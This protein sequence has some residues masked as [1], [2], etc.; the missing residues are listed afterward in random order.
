MKYIG[1]FI[2]WI[3]PKLIEYLLTHDGTRRPGGG[4]NPDSEEFRR[5]TSVGYD[6]TKTYWH[7]YDDKSTTL[8]ITPPIPVEGNVLWWFIKMTPG[9]FMPMHKDPHVTETGYTNCT[10]YWM[11]LQDYQDGHIFLYNQQFMHGYKAGDLWAY[12]DA[13]EI[14]GACNIGYT[15]RLTFQFTT[16][17]TNR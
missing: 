8:Q 2:D 12:D 16:Y 3:T 10:R 1:N 11:P 9:Q 13:N 6:L 14:H 15:P 4:A 5:A 17:E 7:H